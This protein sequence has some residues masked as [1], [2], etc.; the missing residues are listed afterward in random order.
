MDLRK[1]QDHAQ[2]WLFDPGLGL[3]DHLVE[4][5]FFMRVFSKFTLTPFKT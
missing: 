2:A 1:G 5:T 4:F 3:R